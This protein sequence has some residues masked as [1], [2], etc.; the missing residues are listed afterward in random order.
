[1]TKVPTNYLAKVLLQL[2]A[3]NMI[4]G[5]RGGHQDV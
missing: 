1:M 5:R 2:A 4:T 3:A